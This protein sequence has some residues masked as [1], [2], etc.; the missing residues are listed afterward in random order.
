M[1]SDWS[2]RVTIFS[3]NQ[4]EKLM[5]VISALL[6]FGHLF[7]PFPVLAQTHPGYENFKLSEKDEAQI[8]FARRRYKESIEK[9]KEVLKLEGET[10]SSFRMMLKAWKALEGLDRKSVV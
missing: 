6:F 8:L 4:R 2:Y 1:D 10:S 3:L 5:V 7:N 9:F